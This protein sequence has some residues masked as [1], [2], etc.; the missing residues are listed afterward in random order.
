MTAQ[1]QLLE[2]PPTEAGQLDA[3]IT[4]ARSGGGIRFVDDLTDDLTARGKSVWVD[5]QDIEAAAEWR[6][7][8][9][10]AIESAK[11]LLFILSPESLL[12]TECGRELEIATQTQKLIVP[13]VFK[14]VDPEALPPVLADRNWIFFRDSDDRAVAMDQIVQAL[15]FDL[16]WRD[17]HT[18]LEVRAHE[19]SNANSD[20]SYL[21]RGTDLRRAENWHAERASHNE[22]PTDVQ[23]SYIGASTRAAARRQRRIIIGVGAALVVSILLSIVAVVKSIDAT[24][25]AY[26]SQSVAMAAQSSS[27]LST[28]LPLGILV[29]IEARNRADTQQAI[30]ALAT[31]A[32]EPLLTTKQVQASGYVET[33]AFSPDGKTLAS[34][35]D[36]GNLILDNLNS[37]RTTK[38]RDGNDVYSVAFS[39]DGPRRCKRQRFRRA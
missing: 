36:A 33:L 22:L 25:S 34:G 28:N 30:N 15:E 9:S 8:I 19:W 39:P 5:R 38:V 37:G 11:A 31:A 14:D 7:R 13:V 35:G 2:A 12:S 20:D 16:E 18:R 6:G 23:V 27:L 21:L 29:A 1:E 17:L 10:R 4:Y 32:S 26:R 3:F 24:D